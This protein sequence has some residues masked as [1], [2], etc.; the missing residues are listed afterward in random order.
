M[1]MAEIGPAMRTVEI[2]MMG[3]HATQALGAKLA[4]HARPGVTIALIGGLGAGKTTLTRGF[5]RAV[6]VDDSAVS[7]P[8][9][10]LH[11]VYP[12]AKGWAIHHF[13]A[14]RLNDPDQFEALGVGEI[15]DSG[16]VCLVEWADK[17]IESLPA[18]AWRV[19]L[20]PTGGGTARRARLTVPADVAGS[21]ETGGEQNKR[22][23]L[24]SSGGPQ[25]A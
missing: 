1:T 21:L 11:H 5:A 25:P 14:Y 10:V 9:Y 2:D 17:A 18:D 12:T 15:F 20:W 22:D 7:S 3:D 23:R 8:T 4:E 6:G 24:K 13:D 19:E 16:G